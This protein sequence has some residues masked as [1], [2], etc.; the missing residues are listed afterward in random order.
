MRDLALLLS[1]CSSN[2]GLRP[3][4]RCRRFTGKTP[5]RQ[6]MLPRSILLS[7]LITPRLSDFLL[8]NELSCHSRKLLL[9]CVVVL[10]VLWLCNLFN[11]SQNKLAAN[12]SLAKMSFPSGFLDFWP[13]HCGSGT[14]QGVSTTSS[15]SHLDSFS[16]TFLH[17][18]AISGLSCDK[19]IKI[20]TPDLYLL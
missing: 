17:A 7:R 20:P 3:F 10:R 15:L 16:D 4:I 5:L 18:D 6:Q 9:P 2:S 11:L 12:L 1:Q 13:R 19:Y 14:W 8:Q